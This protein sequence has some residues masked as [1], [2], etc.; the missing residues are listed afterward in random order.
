MIVLVRVLGSDFL[1]GRRSPI[2]SLRSWAIRPGE[3]VVLNIQGLPPCGLFRGLKIGSEK[4]GSRLTFH[5]LVESGDATP[6][7][8]PFSFNACRRGPFRAVFQDGA[9]SWS[10]MRRP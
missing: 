5:F 3:T 2:S 10:R 6:L 4:L 7:G 1:L 8:D 9:R